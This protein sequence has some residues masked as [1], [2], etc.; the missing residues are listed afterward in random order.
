MPLG[1]AARIR[2][3]T[4]GPITRS[5]PRTPRSA[6][7]S[8]EIWRSGAITAQ[9]FTGAIIRSTPELRGPGDRT[10][11]SGGQLHHASAAW[12]WA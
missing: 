11:R 10:G 6:N 1:A 7:G 3:E 12:T 5:V 4:R 9:C 2:P 8:L